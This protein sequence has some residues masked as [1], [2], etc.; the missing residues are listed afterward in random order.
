MRAAAQWGI[1][2]E[3]SGRYISGGGATGEREKK[4]KKRC[5]L[6]RMC[7]YVERTFFL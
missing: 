2:Q 7:R 1:Y 4:K 3:A 5:I 6:G